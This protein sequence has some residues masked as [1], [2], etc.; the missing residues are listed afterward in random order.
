MNKYTFTY[1][2]TED[3]NQAVC[4]EYIAY[5]FDPR[6]AQ[7]EFEDWLQESDW[8]FTQISRSMCVV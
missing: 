5:A 4:G 2:L 3:D 8:K 7:D 6:D 1:C